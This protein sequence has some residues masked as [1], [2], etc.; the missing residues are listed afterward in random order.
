MRSLTGF[1]VLVAVCLALGTPAFA[2]TAADPGAAATAPEETSTGSGG[3][4][5]GWL[6]GVDE[7]IDEVRIGGKVKL[8]FN[9]GQR[10]MYDDNIYLNA[11]NEPDTRGRVGS[12]V[13]DTVLGV[14]FLLPTNPDYSQFFK[15]DSI[16]IFRYEFGY[17][18]YFTDGGVNHPRHT[19]STDLFSFF[20]DLFKVSGE[21]SRFY[22]RI[23]N[24][25]DFKTDPLDLKLRNLSLIG[26]PVINDFQRLE[27]W[28]NRFDALVGYNGN[29]FKA[30]ISYRNE[31]FSFTDREF[32]QADHME[33]IVPVRFGVAI[34]QHEN[35]VVY[36][37]GRYRNL[38]YRKDILN[39]AE[40]WEIVGGFE[41]SI[42]SRRMTAVAEAGY[43]SWNSKD[44]G[45]T[46]DDSDY[47][48]FI[49]LLR[50]VY[51][52]W[53]ERKLQF[54]LEAERRVQWSAIANYLVENRGELSVIYEFIPRRLEGD[55]TLAVRDQDESDGPS[56][57]LWEVGL[58]VR[59]HLFKQVDLTARYLYRNQD[60]RNEIV[61]VD[62]V[63]GVLRQ[64]NGDFYQNVISVGI[65]VRF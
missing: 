16:T 44:N 50:L 64:T 58:G 59:Y 40:V 54:Q 45:L 11:K 12:W 48:G 23:K 53:E 21:G 19:F 14:A 1:A 13:S 38:N 24:D 17:T 57:T 47:S 42:I 39:D 63:T 65:E 22:F 27:R 20:K 37:E 4:V 28:E 7:S 36:L 61:Y 46:A 31:W 52:P 9:F 8:A 6:N 62:P 43:S 55:L 5:E 34:P 25:L 2:E 30:T 51:R 26:L 15:R 60:S 29:R 18:A 10:V 35:K 41:G 3:G 49:G 33:H 56:R 32:Q